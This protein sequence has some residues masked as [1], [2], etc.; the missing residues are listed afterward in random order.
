M[1]PIDLEKQKQMTYM[2]KRAY[3]YLKY[4]P[5]TIVEMRTF[6][7]EKASQKHIDEDVIEMV[8]D[9]LVG[10]K[11]LNDA[12]FVTWYMDGRYL[13]RKKSQSLLRR[14]IEHLGVD[15]L[16]IEQVLGEPERDEDVDKAAQAVSALWRRSAN[17]PS[18]KRRQKAT[19]YLL[20]RGYSYDTIKNAIA[21]Q[22]EDD[23][24]R[25]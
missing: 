5:R 9:E 4:R 8:I 12:A 16:L 17:L 25:P 3:H 13:S 23:Y 24:N 11:Y 15:R 2:L 20:R 18:L 10:F 6:L 22:G 21:K 1:V 14:E 7:Q 19:Q